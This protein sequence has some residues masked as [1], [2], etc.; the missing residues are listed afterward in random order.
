M[1]LLSQPW[2]DRLHYFS[3]GL[4]AVGLPLSRILMSVGAILLTLEFILGGSIRE[5]LRRA[6]S[7]PAVLCFI[8]LYGIHLLGL[9]HTS[10][11]H[12]AY[13]DLR[14][15]LPILLFPLVMGGRE[16][17]L[18]VAPLLYA[19]F[20][21]FFL[22]SF[23]SYIAWQEWVELAWEAGKE[24]TLFI[25]AIRLSLMGCLVVFFAPFLFLETKDR[26]SKAFFVLIMGWS[27]FYLTVL[28]TGISMLIVL[29]LLLYLMECWRRRRKGYLPPLLMILLILIPFA[30][31]FWEVRNFYEV[32]ESPLNK[33]EQLPEHTAN[34]TA[35]QH[36]PKEK[37]LENGYY[38]HLYVCPPELK[39][40]WNARSEIPFSGKDREGNLLRTTLI[41]YMTSKGLKKDAE[42]MKKMSEADIQRVEEGVANIALYRANPVR[43]RVQRVIFSLDQYMRGENPSGNSLTMRF[44]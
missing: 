14:I 28:A 27:L 39:K 8:A 41:R 9:I 10:A 36:H 2:A 44:E 13:Q 1:A 40:A 30:Y 23:A 37:V 12:E 24:P 11:L 33:T 19:F 43:K 17:K 4:I 20:I 42:G 5:R 31:L 18:P 26:F 21:A 7:D 16:K 32:E 3:L 22:S 35:Y 15:K 29:A 34:G 38:V 25:S 6:C